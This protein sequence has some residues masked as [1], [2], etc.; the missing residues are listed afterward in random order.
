MIKKL[1]LKPTLIVAIAAGLL[2]LA[3]RFSLLGYPPHT[4]EGCYTFNALM[5]QRSEVMLPTAPINLYP[6]I[7]A[8][9]AGFDET[10]P[11]LRFRL[12]DA[13]VACL[14]SAFFG[15]FLLRWVRFYPALLAALGWAFVV[16]NPRFIDGGFKSPIIAATLMLLITLLLLTS[17]NYKYCFAAGLVIPLA[18]L[19]REAFMFV[20]LA[21]TIM[22]LLVHRRK[23]CL[24]HLAGGLLSTAILLTWLSVTHGSPQAIVQQYLD[25]LQVTGGGGDNT[26]G[27]RVA[28]NETVD[29]VRWLLVPMILGCVSVLWIKRHRI[30]PYLLVVLLLLPFLPEIYGKANYP[31]H[32]AQ[33]SV[34]VLFFAALGL[35]YTVLGCRIKRGS[36][37]AFKIDIV[38]LKLVLSCRLK[39]VRSGWIYAAC[40]IC[41]FINRSDATVNY[42]AG[43]KISQEFAPVI[44]YGDWNSKAVERSF[45]LNTAKYLRDNTE[46]DDVVLTS[47]YYYVLY[48]LTNRWPANPEFVDI[49]FSRKA[50]HLKKRPE[51][52]QELRVMKIY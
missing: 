48:P 52:V 22:C 15:V 23:G 1:K 3:L 36:S 31:Y 41:L 28:L 38:G 7:A 49:I 9:I 12:F 44:V 34:G 8:A 50:G 16:C 35:H 21:T 14:A 4:D 47:G 6:S 40:L 46:P 42:K 51:L 45:F 25:L 18:V 26:E 10:R 11:L 37:G 32:W 17:K 2:T 19:F 39:G 43:L 24:L 29:I 20:P 13:F 5:S 30:L 27:R 33:L